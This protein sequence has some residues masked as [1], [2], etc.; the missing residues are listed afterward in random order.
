MAQASHCS[1]VSPRSSP[2]INSDGAQPASTADYLPAASLYGTTYAGGATSN[3][4]VFRVDTDGGNFTNLHSFSATTNIFGSQVNGDGAKPLSRLVLAGALYGTAEFGG[5]GSG[6]LFSVNTDGSNFQSPHLFA[7]TDPIHDGRVPTAGLVL[8]GATFF[9]VTQFGGSN[10]SGTIFRFQWRN[11]PVVNIAQSGTNVVLSW[12]LD[13]F[14]TNNFHVH[15]GINREAWHRR[16]VERS[17]AGRNHR[18]QPEHRHQSRRL[19][20]SV[21]PIK[22][23]LKRVL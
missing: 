15:T 3:G 12:Q 1:R 13:A 20:Y 17:F 5:D 21:L 6:T 2:A 4:V 18:E 16:I 10:I 22:P 8:S 9:G 11:T 19:H 7:S 23:L 14:L